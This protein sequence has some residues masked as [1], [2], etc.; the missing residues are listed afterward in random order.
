MQTTDV[1]QRCRNDSDYY[2]F[3]DNKS[4]VLAVAHLD[5]VKRA[6]GRVGAR[7]V[8]EFVATAKRP[9]IA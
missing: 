2:H 1:E 5:T 3:K 6:R 9:I 4:R 7:S 8:Y